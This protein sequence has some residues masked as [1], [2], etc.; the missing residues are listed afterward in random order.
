[1]DSTYSYRW[2]TITKN[3]VYTYD[4][5][6]NLTGEISYQ[7]S[8]VLGVSH[9]RSVYSYDVNGNRTG[10]TRYD[11]DSIYNGWVNYS[12]SV[13]KHPPSQKEALIHTHRGL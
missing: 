7:E 13:C 8:N 6:G 4:A 11:W 12:R 1:M 3:C 2:D 10:Y 9:N 5:N